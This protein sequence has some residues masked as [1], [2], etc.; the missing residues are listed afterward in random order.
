MFRVDAISIGATLRKVF[1]FVGDEEHLYITPSQNTSINESKK[2]YVFGINF[3]LNTSTFVDQICLY[4]QAAYS[5]VM[6]SN[7]NLWY[8]Q[9]NMHSTLD[10][11]VDCL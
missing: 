2:V 10:F 9:D 8:V 4:P 6:L 3:E 5:V 7:Y 11:L 1:L